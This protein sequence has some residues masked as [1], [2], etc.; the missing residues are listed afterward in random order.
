MF[1]QQE[2]LETSAFSL[3]LTL[4]VEE[5]YSFYFLFSCRRIDSPF[6]VSVPD[7]RSNKVDLHETVNALKYILG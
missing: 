3:F 1:S 5:R 2:A 6:F 4:A 7:T